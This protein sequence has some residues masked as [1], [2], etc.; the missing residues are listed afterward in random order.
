[1]IRPGTGDEG[2]PGVKETLPATGTVQRWVEMIEEG[3]WLASSTPC[4]AV[5]RV[6]G[7]P[8]FTG[9]QDKNNQHEM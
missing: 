6:L 7:V 9:H 3:H 2:G 4:W 8:Y 1:M 5:L